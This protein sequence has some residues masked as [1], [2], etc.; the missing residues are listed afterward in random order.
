MQKHQLFGMNQPPTLLKINSRINQRGFRG[1]IQT[2]IWP[3]Q[4]YLINCIH[5]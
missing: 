5:E 2:T 3:A 1:F 4:R